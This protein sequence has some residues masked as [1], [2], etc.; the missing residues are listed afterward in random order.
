M[1]EPLLKIQGKREGDFQMNCWYPVPYSLTL[2]KIICVLF[3]VVVGGGGGG[4]RWKRL[5]QN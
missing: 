5:I 4:D 2:V 1:S 3:V